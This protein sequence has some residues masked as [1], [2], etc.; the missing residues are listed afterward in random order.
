M[1]DYH[2]QHEILREQRALQEALQVG[3]RNDHQVIFFMNVW[4]VDPTDEILNTMEEEGG[5]S[6]VSVKDEFK[7]FLIISVSED[8]TGTKKDPRWQLVMMK[9][10]GKNDSQRVPQIKEKKHLKDLERFEF[11]ESKTGSL[12]VTFYFLSKASTVY[13]LKAQRGRPNPAALVDDLHV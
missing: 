13:C 1:V 11:T 6:M 8:A 2:A 5:D 9:K 10:K 7:R 4:P 3:H 12:R